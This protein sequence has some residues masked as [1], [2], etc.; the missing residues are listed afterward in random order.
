MELTEADR[1]QLERIAARTPFRHRRALVASLV[2]LVAI[3]LFSCVTLFLEV[4]RQARAAG[5]SSSIA[6]RRLGMGVMK[7]GNLGL[8]RAVADLQIATV[9][10]MLAASWLFGVLYVDRLETLLTRLWR[11]I[12]G[13]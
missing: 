8:I 3:L 10:L 5:L 9:L 7:T 1:E 11:H 4:A 2:A 6:W 12:R 13:G